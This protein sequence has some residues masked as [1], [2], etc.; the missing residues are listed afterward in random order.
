MCGRQTWCAR[1]EACWLVVEGVVGRWQIGH[2]EGEGVEIVFSDDEWGVVVLGGSEVARDLAGARFASLSKSLWS[3]RSWSVTLR[4]GITIDRYL[5][6][7][8]GLGDR[9]WL[10]EAT[11]DCGTNSMRLRLMPAP[12]GLLCCSGLMN[13][14][15]ES[16]PLWGSMAATFN[17][18][19]A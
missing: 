11:V 2:R 4:E 7:A 10:S 6:P 3:L 18:M 19:Q 5:S 14:G 8:G 12:K 17:R 1:V 9:I 16:A 13:S 15:S